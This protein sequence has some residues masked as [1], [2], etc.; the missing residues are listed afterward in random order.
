MDRIE[1]TDVLI[2]GAG[3]CGLMLA[4]ELGRRG[5]RALVIDGKGG[6]AVNPQANATQARTMEH[7]RRLGFA[8][9]V[10]AL[11]LPPDYPTDIAY[12]TRFSTHEIARFSLPAAKDATQIV[13]G[14]SGSWSAAELPHR[15]SQKFV[16]PVLLKHA[17]ALPG[18]DVRFDTRLVGFTDHGDRVEAQA[19]DAAGAFGVVAR[20]L[21]GAD[22]ARSLVRQTLGFGWGG[23]TG[24]ARDFMGGRMLA[25]YVRCPDFYA[26]APH[27]PAWMYVTF[28]HDR[29]AFMAAVD[30]RS[31]FAFHTQLRPGESE[32]AITDAEALAMFRQAF[33]AQVPAEVVSKN[34]WTAGHAL[35]ADGMQKGRVFIGGDAAHLFTPAGGMGYNT[36]IEDAVNLG[37]KLAHAV[38][39][40]AGPGLLASYEAERRRVAV[41]NT[42]F[43]RQLADSL[44]NYRAPDEIEAETPEGEAARAAAGAYFNRH[45]RAEFNIPGFTLGARYDGSP[46]I[47]GDGSAPP[48]DGPNEYHPTACPGGR[49]PH[50]W[51]AD[52]TSLY[53]RFNFEWTLLRLGANAPSAHAFAAA[54]A[55]RGLDLR[56]VDVAS[57]EARDL[58][59]ADLALIR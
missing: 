17:R 9:E 8:D 52:G 5:V 44:G 49:A 25:V 40:V 4:N 27:A 24:V 34:A 35:V 16:E 13:R 15:V 22:G 39:G 7:Y 46:I 36:A 23:E 19:Q 33:G 10:R 47:V 1:T 51:L 20:Y 58:Y 57:A 6:T 29:R 21:V 56:V 43:A 55:A 12:F 45:A 11:G 37:W 42:G 26:A 28:N 18:I 14:L 32:E 48:P 2:A 3:P 53:D 31:Q 59:E 38:R 30:G 54:A 50:L 41:R